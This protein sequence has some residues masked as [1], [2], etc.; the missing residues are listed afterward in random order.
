MSKECDFGTLLNKQCN[1][2]DY[3]RPVALRILFEF[4][5]PEQ[6]ISFWRANLSQ[7]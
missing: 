3:T 7:H 4:N 1:K 2:L 6:L 5:E